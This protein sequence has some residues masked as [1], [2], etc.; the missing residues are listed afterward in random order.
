MCVHCMRLLG[1]GLCLCVVCTWKEATVAFFT[2]SS[3]SSSRVG[4]STQRASASVEQPVSSRSCACVC[5]VEGGEWR[6]GGGK[7]RGGVGGGCAALTFLLL[8]YA[9][10]ASLL[11]SPF[12]ESTFWLLF[13]IERSSL[14]PSC[15]GQSQRETERRMVRQTRSC[16]CVAHTYL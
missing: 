11:S 5:R 4:T 16:C 12:L 6:G 13:S 2:I 9:A 8:S 14:H 1:L 3:F 10:V 7:E 15:A